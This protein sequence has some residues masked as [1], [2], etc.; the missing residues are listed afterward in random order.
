MNLMDA[1]VLRSIL[2]FFLVAIYLISIS[3]LSRRKLSVWAYAFWGIFA[4]LLP[5]FG[6]FFLI[7]Y[8]PGEPGKKVWGCNL[9]KTVQ[10]FR[11]PEL[12]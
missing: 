9:K 10:R 8:R 3:F 12:T 6:P 1:D 11:K 4:L 7:A 2:I 5:A